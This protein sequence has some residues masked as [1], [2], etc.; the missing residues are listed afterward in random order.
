MVK[1][2]RV[3]SYREGEQP[4]VHD[5]PAND[6]YAIEG[7]FIEEIESQKMPCRAS[8]PEEAHLFF[9]PISVANIVEYVYKPI[10]S[11]ADYDR[12]RLQRIVMDYIQVVADKHPYWNRSNGADHFMLSCHD[13]VR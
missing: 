9:L 3:W 1:R 6:I 8:H 10:V 4:L 5:G 2:F 12:D 7:Q 13:W 11:P